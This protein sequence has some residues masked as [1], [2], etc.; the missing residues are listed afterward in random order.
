MLLEIQELCVETGSSDDRANVVDRVSLLIPRGKV[1]ALVGE[2]GCGKSI[3]AL[4]ILRLLPKPAVRVI[5]GEINWYGDDAKFKVQRSKRVGNEATRQRGKGG[6]GQENS[7]HEGTDLLQL[8]DLEMRA[9]RGRE[10]AMI[11]QEPMTAL[12][13]VFSVGEQIVEVLMLHR[14]FGR[15]EAWSVAADLFQQVGIAEPHR[16]VRDYPHQL[17]GGMR[18]RVLIAM[19]LACQPQLLIADEPTTALDVTIQAQILGLLREI[20]A[21]THMSILLITHDLGVVAQLADYVYVMYAGRIVEHAATDELFAH[22]MHPYT[23]GLFHCTPR[24]DDSSVRLD[25][26]RGSV[27]DPAHFPTGCRFHPRCNLSARGASDTKRHTLTM[28]GGATVLKRC[29]EEFDGEP[30]G[31]PMLRESAPDHFVSCWEA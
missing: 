7:I 12:H 15:K 3:T 5:G 4:S 14:Q 20:Q 6:T 26:I 1:V 2:S 11:F 22:P 24:L 8:S 30:S 29:A 16:R 28:T 18:Q 23:Q 21:K 31:V 13:P 10:I 17:S 19:A 9:M 27:P 25:A